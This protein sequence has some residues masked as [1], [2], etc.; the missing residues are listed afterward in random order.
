MTRIEFQEWLKTC[1][2]CLR[3]LRAERAP[4]HEIA[5]WLDER[6]FCVERL[7]QIP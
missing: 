1:D 6:Q 3:Q 2:D 7:A 4:H 5:R